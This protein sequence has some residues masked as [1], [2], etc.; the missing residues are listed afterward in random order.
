MAPRL[1]EV[2]ESRSMF[3]TDY[4]VRPLFYPVLNGDHSALATV[5]DGLARSRL[6]QSPATAEARSAAVPA[7]ATGPMTRWVHETTDDDR[8]RGRQDELERLNRWVRD[9]ATR[10]LGVCAV[11]GAGKTALVGHWLKRTT[12]WLDIRFKHLISANS[13]RRT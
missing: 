3:E 5:L 4:H 12:G 10:V 2:R 9:E 1:E 11:G 8:F 7:D 6:A 13:A